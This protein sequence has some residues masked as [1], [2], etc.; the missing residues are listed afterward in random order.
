MQ[1]CSGNLIW[2]HKPIRDKYMG[3]AG[4]PSL[5][6]DSNRPEIRGSLGVEAETWRAVRLF[7][8][9]LGVKQRHKSQCGCY[10]LWNLREDIVLGW[11][12][13]SSSAEW[14]F[15][16]NRVQTAVE[17]IDIIRPGKADVRLQSIWAMGRS[18]HTVSL[19]CHRD[20]GLN[21]P[22]VLPLIQKHS[23]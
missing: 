22:T 15:K 18:W 7:A 19:M 21:K 8:S 11:S 9:G 23:L 10:Q 5:S 6:H 4:W 12:S 13:V 16:M 20:A 17:I 2:C 3:E 14:G 1:S